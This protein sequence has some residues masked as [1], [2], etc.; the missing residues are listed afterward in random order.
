MSGQDD[1]TEKPHEATP[2]KLDEARKRGEMPRTSDLTAAAATAGLLLI[3]PL[4]G[5][6]APVRLGA[7]GM[8]LIDRAEQL[9]PVFLG[10]GTAMTGTV[11]KQ[12]GLALAP[13]ALLPGLLALAVLFALRGVVFAPQKLEPKLSRISLLSNA[14]N[15]F[16]LSG[17]ME[18]AKSTLK[19]VIYGLVLWLFLRARLPDLLS[20]LGQSP[21]P[22]TVLMLRMMAEFLAIVVAIMV[23]IG[24]VDY[25]WQRF[26]HHRKQRMSHQELRED[27]KQAEGDPHLKQKRRQRAT[28]F[29]SNRML[30][31]VPGAAVVIVNPTHYA[32]ALKWQ[33]GSAGA[34]VCVAKGTDE[35]AARIREIAQENHV[36]V[37]SDPPTARALFATTRI[38]AE[39]LPE[40]YREVAAAIRFAD[41]MRQRAARRGW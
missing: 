9:G 15:K 33:A 7:L 40:H 23:V 36:P 34:P 32:V 5:G 1:D 31:D 22:V 10:G 16:G 30:T 27:H 37:H 14:K 24:V 20:A 38:G 17:L 19:L 12:I 35:I 39:I 28:E 8:G 13:V 2:R 21:G 18:F 6:W 3:T 29:A 25:L 4:P 26:D 41:E 11:L